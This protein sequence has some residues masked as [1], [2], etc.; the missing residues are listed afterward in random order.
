MLDS[1]QNLYTVA[2][3][4]IFANVSF[5]DTD[6]YVF[7]ILGSNIWKVANIDEEHPI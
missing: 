2:D 1:P 5:P 3:S 4:S 7:D 6:I